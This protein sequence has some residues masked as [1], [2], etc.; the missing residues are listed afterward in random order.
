MLQTHKHND[1]K[2]HAPVGIKLT[3]SFLNEVKKQKKIHLSD[4]EIKI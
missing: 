4:K 1:T 3:T 2:D